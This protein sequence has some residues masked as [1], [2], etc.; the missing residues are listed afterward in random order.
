MKLAR[1]ITLLFLVPFLALLLALGYRTTQREVAI[2]EAQVAADLSITAKAL[3]PSF[4]EVL[5]VDGE[6]RALELLAVSDRRLD[7]M[8]VRWVRRGPE[9]QLAN[10]GDDPVVRIERGN[11]RGGRATVR[12]PVGGVGVTFGDLELSRPLDKE[13]ELTRSVIRDEALTTLLA[14]LL[15]VAVAVIVG[16]VFIGGPIRSL[17]EQVRRVGKGDLSVRLAVA[18]ADELGELADE[19]DGMCTQL[20]DGRE[21]LKAEGEA[22]I[23]T[24]EQLRHADRLST[25]GKLAAGLAHE[26]GTPLNVVS[27]RAKMIASG[28]LAPQVAAENATIIRGQ[29]DR[30]TKII[31]QLLDFARQGGARKGRIDASELS[32]NVL[33]LLTPLAKKR[34]VTLSLEGAEAARVVDADPVQLEQLVTNLVV[35]GVDA[36]REGGAVVVVLR[37]EDATAPAA[38][39]AQDGSKHRPCLRLDVS[40]EGTGIREE[41]LA[42]VFEPFFTTKEV[43]AGTGLGLAVVHGIVHDHGGWIAVTSEANQGSCFSVYLPLQSHDV[44]SP[45]RR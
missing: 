3:R 24:L 27:G 37:E 29:A 15:T 5:R 26:L 21:A 19:V 11:G 7:D 22:R 35:N 39:G 18:R 13:D 34:G 33:A 17:V 9:A 40:D 42:H 23:K 41:D 25:V 45:R 44:P 14:L 16:R 38:Q 32:R 36:S 31:R 6:A 2:Y 1:K 28:S 30:M 12:L 8:T 4:T 43:G 10:A 20:A